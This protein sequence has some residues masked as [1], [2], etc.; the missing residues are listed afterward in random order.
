MKPFD[1][2]FVEELGQILRSEVG[3]EHYDRAGRVTGTSRRLFTGDWVLE[4]LGFS[5]GP[6]RDTV[7]ARFSSGDCQV[8]AVLS[9]S[10]FQDFIG[11]NRPERRNESRHSDLAVAASFLI[12]EQILHRPPGQPCQEVIP[13]WPRGCGPAASQAP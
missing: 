8:T 10:D 4:S 13:V 5:P 9:A 12:E 11:P 7:L 2:K 3:V 6:A 1:G